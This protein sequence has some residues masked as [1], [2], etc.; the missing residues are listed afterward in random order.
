MKV[1]SKLRRP[2]ARGMDNMVPVLISSTFEKRSS[3]E[4]K[5]LDLQDMVVFF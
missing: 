3:P 1:M 2:A 5:D 4:E